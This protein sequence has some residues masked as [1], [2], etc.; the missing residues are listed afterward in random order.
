MK[1]QGYN[2]VHYEVKNRW[3]LILETQDYQVALR[4]FYYQAHTLANISGEQDE[5]YTTLEIEKNTYT[6]G[7][8]LE[9]ETILKA[10]NTDFD[11]NA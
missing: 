10:V 5:D 3:G 8:L 9:S 7:R 1:I 11:F 4:E 6:N 2:G